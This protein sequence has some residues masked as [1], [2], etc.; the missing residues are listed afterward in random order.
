[1]KNKF[2]IFNA[3]AISI[4]AL[5]SAMNLVVNNGEYS[6]L[7]NRYLQ[8]A[9]EI[10]FESIKDRSFMEEAE[11]Y[12]NDQLMFRDTF[13]KTK[14]FVEKLTGKKE[15]NG[16][17]FAKDGYIIE[18]PAELNE[19]LIAKNIESAKIIGEMGRFDVTFCLI[20]QAFEIH[21]EKLPA[22][23]YHDAIAK[24]NEKVNAELSET[25]VKNTDVLDLLK[26]HK[27]DEI[28][29]RTDHHQTSLGSYLVYKELG[30][31]L[32]YRPLGVGDFKVDTVSDSFLGTTYSK[33]LVNTGADEIKAYSTEISRSATVEFY[34]EGK[35]SESIFFPEHLEKKDQ[36]SYF[37]DGNHG[38]TVV[39]SSLENGRK[40]ALFKDSYAH[41]LTPFL[42]NH[43]ESI[44][45]IDMRYFGE[46]PIKYLTDNEITEILFL[47]GSSTFMTDE[48]IG[49][50]GEY[51]INSPYAKFG[52]VK[53]CDA[54]GNEY[55]SDAVFLGDSITM[56]FQAYSGITEAQYA[57]STAMSVGGV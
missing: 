42:I 7:E 8:S 14:A 32:D 5:F 15:N 27:N 44:H 46:D 2:Y 54:V 20:P 12:S 35:T 52:L 9:P 40:I 41:S 31:Q 4:F 17:Y 36:Y 10:S 57:C 56:G 13:V 16:V 53:E 33:G 45:L 11:D 50:T 37:L 23:A 28:F 6:Y 43:F 39:N 30:E 22:G 51:G 29:Y 26:M 19:E 47:Y 55:F 1:M 21:K 25:D 3:I 24:L 38:V 34:G 18:K 49:K 48:T